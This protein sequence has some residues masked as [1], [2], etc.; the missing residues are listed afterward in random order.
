MRQW[1]KLER[2]YDMMEAY[3]QK[4]QSFDL[5]LKLRTEARLDA[6]QPQLSTS[7]YRK[8]VEW[9]SALRSMNQKSFSS[10]EPYITY[11]SSL[12][13]DFLRI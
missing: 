2:A 11:I 9:R 1:F 12:A 13:A 5:V 3:E 7:P 8:P 10:I 4:H 6:L